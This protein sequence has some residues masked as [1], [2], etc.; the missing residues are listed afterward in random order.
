MTQLRVFVLPGGKIQIM[1]DDGSFE[2]AKQATELLLQQLQTA[3]I[4]VT[5]TSEIEQHR[6]G[7]SH[8]HVHVQEHQHHEH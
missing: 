4:P 8:V 6:V 7:V 5:L 2:E 3:G 1:G